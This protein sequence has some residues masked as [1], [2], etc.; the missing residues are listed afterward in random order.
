MKLNLKIITCDT[1]AEHYIIS[2]SDIKFSQADIISN[3]YP[4]GA[5]EE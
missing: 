2:N 3:S 5:I 4:F 1:K